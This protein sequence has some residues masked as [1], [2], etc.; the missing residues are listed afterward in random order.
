MKNWF[1]RSKIYKFMHDLA[2]CHRSMVA[3]ARFQA[4]KIP[5]LSWPSNAPDLNPIENVWK[6]LKVLVRHRIRK[7]KES[8]GKKRE[9]KSDKMILQEAIHYVW[10]NSEILKKIAIK[11]CSSVKE[12]VEKIYKAKGK[13]IKY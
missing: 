2:P 11:C 1:G 5:L 4:R 10:E 8:L 12:R 6:V 13:W 3:K 9:R 7:V